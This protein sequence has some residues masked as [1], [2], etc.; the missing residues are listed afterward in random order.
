MRVYA[1][2]SD[3]PT[4]CVALPIASLNTGY[5]HRFGADD[6]LIIDVTN[7]EPEQGALALAR[8]GV[9]SGCPQLVIVETLPRVINGDL[10]WLLR[11]LGSFFVD[12]PY[13][14]DGDNA[15]YL[16]S[17]IVGRVVGY[18]SAKG[19]PGERDNAGYGLEIANLPLLPKE[20]LDPREW[21]I[22]A[23]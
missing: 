1:S 7:S 2:L 8:F 4:T 20:P 11:P 21:Q 5:A 3:I 13:A 15:W 9:S 6:C 22:A 10:R 14:H 12:G 16:R 18:G 23:L 19:C 17:V